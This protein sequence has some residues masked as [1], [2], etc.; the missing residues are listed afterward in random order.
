MV[1]WC[2]LAGIEYFAWGWEE[3]VS[4]TEKVVAMMDQNWGGFQGTQ[5]GKWQSR[6]YSGDD[7]MNARLTYTLQSYIFV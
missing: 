2:R 5:Y 7:D 1:W 6:S 3:L 4:G